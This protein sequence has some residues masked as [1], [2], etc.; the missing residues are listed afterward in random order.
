[1]QPLK[2]IKHALDSTI[3]LINKG[4]KPTV[5]LEKVARALDLNPN[6]IQR[7]GE[8]LNVALTYDH[9]KKNASDKAADFDI[10]Q[11]PNVT[12]SIFGSKEKTIA[13]KKAEWFPKVAEDIDYNKFLT[14]PKF[15]KTASEI[16]D[17]DAKHDH[18]GISYKGQFKKAQDYLSK[19]DRDVDEM[20][21]EKV[22]NDIY[23]EGAFF[24]LV[25]GFKK[26][27]SYRTPFHEFESQ[28]Y[29]EHGERAVPYLD[30]IHKA[31]EINDARGTHDK[32]LINFSKCKEAELFDSLLKAAT[33]KAQHELEVKEA[34]EYITSQKKQFKEVGYKLNPLAQA[35]EKAA[36]EKLAC[37]LDTL[38][39]EM[40]K[41]AL[42]EIGK[43]LAQDLYNQW[44][45]T[46]TGKGV[47]KPVFE[48]T[49][50]DNHERRTILQDLIMTDPI[51]KKIDP[52]KI[53]SAYKQ[54]LRLS[55]QLTKEKEVV[56]AQLRQMTAIG[57]GTLHPTDANQLVDVNTN[58]LKQHEMLHKTDGG[59]GDQ[60]KK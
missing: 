56:R 18:F 39:A 58:L 47:K 45:D 12:K 31:A 25:N 16:A 42:G 20:K 29:A 6:Y 24:S 49:N 41:Q 40:E 54:M 30:L 2:L 59:G 23:I 55:P 27:A 43:S 57:D 9:F 34:E 15:K 22:A 36:C 21:T 10:A 37:E 5:A 48:N 13:E 38:D 35:F 4:E 1:M 53:I 19:L 60:K 50:L 11:I 32:G 17:T 26:Q 28:V 7:T 44:R 51:L 14:N 8:A 3:E 52:R 46:T 33:A